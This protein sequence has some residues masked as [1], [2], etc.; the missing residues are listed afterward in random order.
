MIT[1]AQ[2]DYLARQLA[3]AGKADPDTMVQPGEPQMYGTP[4]GVAFV[5]TPGAAVPLWRFYIPAARMALAE[6]EKVLTSASPVIA[7]PELVLSA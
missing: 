2:I 5:V 3:I 7:P 1:D 6:A 4:G